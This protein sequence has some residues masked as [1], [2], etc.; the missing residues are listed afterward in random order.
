[1]AAHRSTGCGVKNVR[2]CSIPEVV[3][4]LDNGEFRVPVL[5]QK[6]LNNLLRCPAPPDLASDGNFT[7]SG[8]PRSPVQISLIYGFWSLS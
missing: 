1:M 4:E 8:G 2:L 5:Q 6:Y 3:I 7:Q